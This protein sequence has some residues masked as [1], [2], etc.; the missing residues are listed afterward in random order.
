M[1]PGC[2]RQAVNLGYYSE[3]D[4]NVAGISVPSSRTRLAH[5]HL[6]TPS[7]VIS[8]RPSQLLCLDANEDMQLLCLNEGEKLKKD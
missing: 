4:L 8:L 2:T 5:Q 1:V 6:Y 7:V 3:D